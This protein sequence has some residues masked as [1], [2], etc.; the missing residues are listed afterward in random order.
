[1]V[2][3]RISAFIDGEASP[4]ETHQAMLRLKQEGE[5]TETFD[6]FHLIGDVMRGAPL[7]KDDFMTRFCARME[8]EPTQ[9][10]PRVWVKKP[11][12]LAFSVAASLSAIGLVLMLAVVDNP[13]RITGVARVETPSATQMATNERP[14]VA[15][16]Q[17]KINEYLMA[18]Q[19]YSPSTALQG[20][21]PYVRTVSETHDGNNR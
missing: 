12:R 8:Q 19:E 9:L 16:N 4:L 6:T 2:M 13:Y 10:A 1:M 11:A 17:G 5:C 7:L 20:L 14:P 18:H 15:I 3:E 21:A